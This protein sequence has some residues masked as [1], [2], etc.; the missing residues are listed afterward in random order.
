MQITKRN[1]LHAAIGG[2]AFWVPS[3]FLHALK[4]ADF[5][6]VNW[7]LLASAQPL[8]T[9]VIFVA[10]CFLGRS[11]TTPRSCARWMLLG[12]WVLGPLCLFISATFDGGGFAQDWAWLGVVIATLFFPLFTLWLSLYDG[13][14]IGLLVS[15]SLLGAAS[16]DLLTILFRKGTSP[17]SSSR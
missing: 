16:S 14:L 7:G 11:G 12:I 6:L 3:I 13:S 1:L 9:L 15:S 4:G 5:L 17:S 2:A 8:S 10:I